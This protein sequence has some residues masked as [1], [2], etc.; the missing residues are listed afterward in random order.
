MCSVE[1]LSCAVSTN[2]Y[3]PPYKVNGDDK[4]K[5]QSIRAV[6][7]QDNKTINY[8]N[9]TLTPIQTSRLEE[10]E[11]TLKRIPKLSHLT[12]MGGPGMIQTLTN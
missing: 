1:C 2:N 11:M 3:D 4:M 10:I 9:R 12:L 7:H 6:V 8:E 5:S